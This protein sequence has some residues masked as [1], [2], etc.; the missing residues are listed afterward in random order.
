MITIVDPSD[1]SLP[2]IINIDDD[3]STCSEA[4]S[5]K[6]ANDETPTRDEKKAKVE[7]SGFTNSRAQINGANLFQVP[8]T[9]RQNGYHL[10]HRMATPTALSPVHVRNSITE[11]PNNP[12]AE[13]LKAGKNFATIAEIRE[14]ISKHSKT[15]VPGIVNDQVHMEMC[16]QSVTPWELPLERMLDITLQMLREQTEAI[17]FEILSKWQQT[18]LFKKARQHL[19]SFFDEFETSQRAAATMLYELESYKLFTVNNIAWEEYRQQE[20]DILKRA[21][22][23][24]RAKAYVEKQVSMRQRQPFKDETAKKK[25]VQE[26]RDEVL[27]KD[28][29]ETEIEVAAYVRGY[30]KTAALRFV[31]SVCLSI[32]GR[33]FRHARQKIFYFLEQQLGLDKGDGEFEY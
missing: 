9:P 18:E 28:P 27:G 16:L 4:A 26:V 29:F 31:D 12:F 20:L 3:E 23:S 1:L 25:A 8:Q 14:R 21:R 7:I 30:Y 11:D 32:H 19:K 2:E 6:R 10:P 22:R 33:L 5:R 15:G 17:L 24:R 13:Y